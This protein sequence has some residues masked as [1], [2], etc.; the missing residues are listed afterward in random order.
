MLSK[1]VSAKQLYDFVL[2][3]H[4]QGYHEQIGTIREKGTSKAEA[5]TGALS[6]V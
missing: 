2:D 1:F 3:M 5:W 4:A 6:E